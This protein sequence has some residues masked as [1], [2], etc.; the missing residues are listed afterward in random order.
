MGWVAQAFD[1]MLIRSI[2]WVFFAES[3]FVTRGTGK[4]DVRAGCPR[5]AP[6]LGAN[7]GDTFTTTLPQCN[8]ESELTAR[9]RAGE[10]AR[11]N[12]EKHSSAQVSSERRVAQLG[13]RASH[14]GQR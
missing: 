7:L 1:E 6:S 10:S 8:F 14:L 5:F 12:A 4:I 3:L 11:R 2:W 13:H 9:D